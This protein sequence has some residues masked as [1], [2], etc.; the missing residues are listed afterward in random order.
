VATWRADDAYIALITQHGETLFR[1]AVL[2]TGRAWGI[3]TTSGKQLQLFRGTNWLVVAVEGDVVQAVLVDSRRDR[4]RPRR[5][6]R[7]LIS[8]PMQYIRS[9][10]RPNQ[11][12][13]RGR[14]G[15]VVCR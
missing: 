14:D 8:R 5:A 7:T 2:L 11:D 9:L 10:S 3:E 15:R 1:L 12:D 4:R 13:R 6:D